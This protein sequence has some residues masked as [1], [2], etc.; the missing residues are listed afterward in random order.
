MTRLSERKTPL[1]ITD[2][3]AQGLDLKLTLPA[4]TKAVVRKASAG[5]PRSRFEVL[6]KTGPG[7]VHLI[8]DVVTDAG[9][10]QPADYGSF[11]SYARDADAALT[12]AIRI[13]G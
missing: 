9:R 5:H 6:D 11:Q 3:T 7:Y 8:R 13:S 12:A 1:L 4:G 2:T 10:V